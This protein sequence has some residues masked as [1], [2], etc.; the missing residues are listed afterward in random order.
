M[1]ARALAHIENQKFHL[2]ERYVVQW[3]RAKKKG[4]QEASLLACS[5]PE[6]MGVE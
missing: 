5:I 2:S 6:I 1:H 4:G 3:P